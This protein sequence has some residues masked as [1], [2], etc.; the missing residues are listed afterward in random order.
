MFFKIGVT[1]FS[2]ENIYF[3]FLFNKVT[4]LMACNFTK[5]ETPTQLF[6]CEYQKMFKKSFFYGAPTVAASENG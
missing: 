5:K 1:N 2:Q 3:E 4:G 6:F